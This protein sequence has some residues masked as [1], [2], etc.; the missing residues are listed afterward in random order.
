MVYR[1]HLVAAI[2]VDGKILR[3]NSNAV[4]VPFGSEYSIFLKNLNSVRTQVK[5]SVDG[6]DATEGAWIVLAPSSSLD[7]ERFIRNGN[8]ERG[9]RF[10]FIE[11]TASVENHR[12][13]GAEDGLVRVEYKAERVAIEQPVI[14]YYDYPVP[15]PCTPRHPIY[16][17]HARGPLRPMASSAGTRRPMHPTIKSATPR[18]DSNIYNSSSSHIS[19]CTASMDCA[20]DGIT[21]SGSE[22]AQQFQMSP[23]FQTENHSEVIVLK[24]RGI[25]AGKAVAQAVTVDRKPKC[26]TCGR[27]NKANSQ[28]CS[29]CGTS[30][31][32]L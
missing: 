20:M 21:V 1:N 31:I 17:S 25:A 27:T 9:N 24:L 5:V 6:Q 12:G 7:L 28:F 13:I 23:W 4:L 30:L 19:E 11:R 26:E 16:P 32:I 2:K 29:N 8:F 14:R 22:S 10:K 15:R 3:E 18:M